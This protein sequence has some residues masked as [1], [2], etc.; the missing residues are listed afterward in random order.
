MRPIPT[1]TVVSI[2]LLLVVA[3]CSSDPDRPAAPTSATSTGESSTPQPD[4]RV[5]EGTG[6]LEPGRWA[7]AA[8]GHA[9]DTVLAELDLE[10]WLTATESSEH[11]LPRGPVGPGGPGTGGTTPSATDPSARPGLLDALREATTRRG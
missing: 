5:V 4:Y 8:N 10:S 6:E 9:E 1:A 3:G 11:L 2:A 7:L